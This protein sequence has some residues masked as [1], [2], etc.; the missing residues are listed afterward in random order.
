ME[1]KEEEWRLAVFEYS[2]F[3]FSFSCSLFFF[4]ARS[5]FLFSFSIHRTILIIRVLLCWFI[6]FLSVGGKTVPYLGRYIFLDG[7]PY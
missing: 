5:N 3:S 4:L 2:A 7:Q 6:I 1:V